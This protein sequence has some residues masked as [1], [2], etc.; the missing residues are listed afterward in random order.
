[1][2]E[3]QTLFWKNSMN[4]G[5]IAGISVIIILVLLY[6]FN[7]QEDFFVSLIIY[8]ILIAIIITGTKYLKN[9]VQNGN[10]TYSRAL[11]SGTLISLFASI[12]IAFYMFV[13]L[14]FIDTEAMEKIFSLMEYKMYGKGLP[15]EQV[16]M[17]ME[18]AKKFTTPVTI[19]LGTI[20]SYTFWGFLFSLIIS[21]FIRKKPNN[22]DAAMAEIKKEINEEN[23]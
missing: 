15:D 3:Q 11:G 19:A 6:F 18:M 22:Y 13:F 9:K 14:K 23:K 5:A 17:A 7:I 12:I 1:M 20:F 16:D 2:S 21:A 4:F 10:I 8:A